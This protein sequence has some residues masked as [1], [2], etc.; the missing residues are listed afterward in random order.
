MTISTFEAATTISNL[1]DWK[2]THLEIQKIMYISS[3]FYMGR[4]NKEPLVDENFQAWNYGPVLPTLYDRLKMFGADNIQNVFFISDISE[5]SKEYGLLKL[6]TGT[7]KEFNSTKL[8]KIT[9]ITGGA[10]SRYFKQGHLNI[11][12]PNEAIYNEYLKFYG[13]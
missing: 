6:I 13:E 1:Y 5:E 12:I 8:V 9:H 4:N 7:T 10:W 11:T 3:V 2:L